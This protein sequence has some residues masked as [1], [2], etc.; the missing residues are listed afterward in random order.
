MPP[1]ELEEA[2][3]S[4]WQQS[5]S[6]RPRVFIIEDDFLIAL[7][8]EKILGDMGCDVVGIRSDV[9]SSLQLITGTQIDVAIVD[10]ILANGT[11]VDVIAALRA[12]KLPCVICSGRPKREMTTAFPDLPSIEKPFRPEEI[13]RVVSQLAGDSPLIGLHIFF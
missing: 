9:N 8:L 10:Y 6:E 5:P 3:R 12:R 2:T 4:P 7:D 13:Y 11:S 1:V